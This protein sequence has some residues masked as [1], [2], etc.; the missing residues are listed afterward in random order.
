MGDGLALTITIAGV[1]YTGRLPL[2]P[3]RFRLTTAYREALGF[4]EGDTRPSREA[5]QEALAGVFGACLGLC[6]A[7]ART[8]LELEAW[9]DLGGELGREL[10][11]YTLPGDA[12]VAIRALGRDLE[13]FGQRVLSALLERGHKLGDL[14]RTGGDL[15]AACSDSIPTA[16]EVGEAAADFPEEPA[17]GSTGTTP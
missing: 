11:R 2:L 8:P 7:D 13:R 9:V 1:E 16:A 15:R 12:D 3:D 10:Q 5:D 17:Q 4:A 6:W 14:Y